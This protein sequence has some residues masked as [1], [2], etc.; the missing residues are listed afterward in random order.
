LG[1][2]IADRAVDE[3]FLTF[4]GKLAGGSG[5]AIVSGLTLPDPRAV[6]LLWLLEQDGS[7]FL[8]YRLG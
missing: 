7:L 6:S 5:S 1:Q 2:L 4:A 8:R 3:L